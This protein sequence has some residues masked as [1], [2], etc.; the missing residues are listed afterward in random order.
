VNSKGA[1]A[2]A[3]YPRR[4]D[5]GDELIQ[6]YLDTARE[7]LHMDVAF[8]T[9]VDGDEQTF[10]HLAGDAES[11]GWMPGDVIPATDG[12]CHYVLKGALPNVVQDAASHELTAAL[13]STRSSRIGSYVGVALTLGSGRVYGALCVSTHRPSRELG[14]SDVA[15]LNVLGRLIS[16]QLSKQELETTAKSFQLRDLAAWLEPG[17]LSVLVQPIVALS[18]GVVQG[19]EALARFPGHPGNPTNVFGAAGLA[20]IGAELE[21][22]AVREAL[23]L[24]EQ[25]PAPLFMAINVSPDTLQD[26]ELENL[27]LAV[28]GERIVLELA[29]H[30][31][32]VDHGELV[33]RIA[34]FRARGIRI[35]VDDAGS[36]YAGLQSLLALD[37]DIVKLDIGL[38]KNVDQDPVRRCLIRSLAE[39]A[40]EI[41]ATVIAE[42]IETRA[43]LETLPTLGVSVGQG[44][45]LAKP[46]PLGPQ[47]LTPKTP[48][49]VS[50]Q[51]L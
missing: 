16:E 41:G 43:E 30:G 3:V 4:V 18:S 46:G 20:G 44:F 33:Q 22:A 19:V 27:L 37:P 5:P 36:G 48:D 23:P 29:D 21:L 8:V 39:F 38:V 50:V 2:T 32:F 34:S 31:S 47:T 35:A 45:H 7:T 25:L 1:L 17:G 15:F 24:L 11:F 10:T 40:G 6:Y 49:S 14:P 9:A 13:P 26:L 51:E 12:Y 42:G 28:P